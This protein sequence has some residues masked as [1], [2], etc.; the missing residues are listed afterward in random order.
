MEK[1]SN[2]A[3][4][5]NNN[6]PAI[7]MRAARVLVVENQRHLS[8][9]LQYVLERAG[10]E[11]C[12]AFDGEQALAAVESF[13]PDAVLLDAVLPGISALELL[14]SLRANRKCQNLVVVMLPASSCA[15]PC[16]EAQ[17][18]GADSYCSRPIVPRALLEKLAEL[19]VPA[20][21]ESAGRG[22]VPR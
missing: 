19:S 22:L 18:A 20:R 13:P 5:P 10:Y 21:C 17:N 9:Y 15:K 14:R 1:L 12:V 11:V 7:S 3:S 8:R 2:T 4:E 6:I 16:I